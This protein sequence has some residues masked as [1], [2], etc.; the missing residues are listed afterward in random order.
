MADYD[1]DSS[2]IDDIETGVTLGY[3]SK[4]ATGDDFSQIGGHPSWLDNDAVPSGALAKCKVCNGYLN[5]L[6]QLNGDLPDRFPGH[7]RR[8]YIFGCKQ[9]TC[10]RKDGSVRG[11]RT[12]RVSKEALEAAQAKASAKEAA[13]PAAEPPK[14]KQTNIGESLFGVQPSKAN[15]NANPFSTSGAAGSGA[16]NPFS[17]SSQPAANP[18][19][20][21]NSSPVPAKLAEKTEAVEKLSQ[22][23]AE[24]ARIASPT[25]QDSPKPTAGP[26]EPWPAQSSFPPPYP[27][28]YIDADKEYLDPEPQAVPQNIRLAESGEFETTASGGSGNSADDKAA[29]DSTMDKLFQRFADRLAQNPEQIL[30][31]EFAGQPL[32]YSKKDVVG[33]AWP[34]VPRCAKCGAERVFELQL[35]PHAIT[36]LEAD[37]LSLEGMDWGTIILASCAADCE[38]ENEEW[39]GVQW[40]ELTSR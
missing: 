33:S 38:G 25:A 21:A 28:Y 17:T 30:R 37:D 20:P 6:M 1:S 18:F 32:L 26:K 23:F 39:V 14:P 7:E 16:A 4:E 2:G 27:H 10:R 11:I 24:K 9:K 34:R 12:T 40:E 29:I 31:Y 3:A 35:T 5:L 36:E 19:A 22:T 13:P 15:Q 8:V